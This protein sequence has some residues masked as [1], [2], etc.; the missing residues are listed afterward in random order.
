MK[1]DLKKAIICFL[2]F[3]ILILISNT[4]QASETID[5][6]D[7]SHWDYIVT[8]TTSSD[9]AYNGPHI[10]FNNNETQEKSIL[11]SGYGRTSY[12][13]FVFKNNYDDNKKVF[14]LIMDDSAANYHS[15]EGAGFMFNTNIDDNGTPNNIDDDIINGYVL[16]FSR[17]VI[18]ISKIENVNLRY[19]HSVDFSTIVPVETNEVGIYNYAKCL[20]QDVDGLRP[21]FREVV[22]TTYH[23]LTITVSKENVY[24][25]DNGIQIF[26][27]D[28]DPLTNPGNGYGLITSYAQHN[29]S[30]L[31][32]ITFKGITLTTIDKTEN[33]KSL[34]NVSSEYV[35][36]SGNIKGELD[37]DNLENITGIKIDLLYGKDEDDTME[38]IYSTYSKD[39]TYNF[40]IVEGLKRNLC[41]VSDSK[42]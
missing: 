34:C 33:I 21:V 41:F 11:F 18:S 3:F 13:D 19:F 20:G 12:K 28:F 32:T 29:C 31:S 4:S 27:F 7:Q 14:N 39:G 6:T 35:K 2:L 42:E 40:N 9:M 30:L 8:E 26:N 22:D 38:T 17:R 23:N 5:L 16:L 24:V 37:I 36:L 10:Y 1:N 25:I 15:I